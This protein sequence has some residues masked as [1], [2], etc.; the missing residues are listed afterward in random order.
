MH[1]PVNR[2]TG[3]TG[4]ESTIEAQQCP[5]T[6]QRCWASIVIPLQTFDFT[7]M[8]LKSLKFVLIAIAF[9]VSSLAAPLQ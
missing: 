4:D 9:A 5:T 1:N 6:L 3:G 2:G 8:H 7:V